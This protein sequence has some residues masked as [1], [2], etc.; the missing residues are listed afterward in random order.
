MFTGIIKGIGEVVAYD[1]ASLVLTIMCPLF[2]ER[3]PELGA[4]IAI[5]GVCL[6]ASHF[7]HSGHGLI[8]FDLGQETRE[9][10]LLA[11]QRPN[12]AVNVEYALRLGDPLDGHMVQGHVDGIVELVAV[13]NADGRTT[14]QF[15]FQKNVAPFIVTKGSI[16]INGISLTVNHVEEDIFS[17]CLV[18]HTMAH[19][20]LQFCQLGDL[21]HIET[22]IIGR[23]IHR[24]AKELAL[25]SLF[26]N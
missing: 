15:R 7:E 11:N 3:T 22:D 14:M 19:T 6:T 12:K 5:D 9:V 23:Y 25:T 26:S 1:E 2:A 21:L 13:D 8:G 24:T 18:P 16:A 17:V 10:T 20:N 4:S